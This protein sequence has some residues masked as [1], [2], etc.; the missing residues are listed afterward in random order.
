MHI[1]FQNFENLDFS[2]SLS[3]FE[4]PD[5]VNLKNPRSRKF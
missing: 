1:L 4:F 5:A 3:A 2:G